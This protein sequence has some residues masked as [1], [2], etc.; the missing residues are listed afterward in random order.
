MKLIPTGRLFILSVAL[1][2]L[3]L[4]VLAGCALDPIVV[5]PPTPTPPPPTPTPL[6]RGGTLTI[7]T[8]TDAPEL[9]PW[10]P[11]TRG[12]EQIIS[13]LYSGLTR[14]DAKLQPQPDLATS[15]TPSADG[16]LITFTLRTDAIWHDGRPVTADDVAYTLSALRELSPTT[17]LLADMHK[18][19]EVTTPATS[20]IVLSLTERYAPIF[21]DLTVPMLPK[22]LLIG[23]N[24]A[25]LNF[26]DAPIGSG[27]FKLADRKP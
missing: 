22:H 10:Q 23:K 27:P 7:R 1:A 4:V 20:T 26:W 17:A 12:E 6:P 13:L 14:L 16:R 25:T 19:A 8:A 18:I 2:L 5:V 9:R 3:L 15:W 21:A 24:I 11:R